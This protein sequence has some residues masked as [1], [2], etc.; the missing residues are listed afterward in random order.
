M[1]PAQNQQG[2]HELMD[3]NS[4]KLITRNIVHSIPVTEVVIKAVEAMAYAQGFTT[5]KF[6]NRN[7]I[8]FHDADWIAGVDYDENQENDN[9]DEYHQDE[10]YQQD[11]EYD[12]HDD[13]NEQGLD[14]I[15]PEEVE[16]IILDNGDTNPTIHNGTEPVQPEQEDE[17]QD[18]Q[19]TRQ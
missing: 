14:E 3:L 19:E 17:A 9:D 16:D 13:D 15:D 7:G 4:G 10:A 8:V 18:A 5:L 12:E 2:G 11:V 1:R 6:K